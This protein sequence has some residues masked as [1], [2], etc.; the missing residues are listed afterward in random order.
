MKIVLTGGPSAGKTAL[1]TIIEKEFFG[2]VAVVPEAASI[3]FKGGFPRKPTLL[4]IKHQQR[5]IYFLQV[6]LEGL[7]E[8]ENP[9]KIIICDRGTLDGS[10]YLQGSITDFYKEVGSSLEKEIQRYDYV[11]H[12]ESPDALYYDFS[13]PLR[14][15]QPLQA[16]QLDEK[17]K[18]VWS[19]H[20]HRHITKN[21]RNF[22][23]KVADVLEKV[24]AIIKD[25]NVTR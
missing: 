22:S 17:I 5:A 7:I 19:S 2:Q 6:E 13:N 25:S 1:V 15:E 16:R 21:N 10:A 9:G 11:L 23:E 12:L 18:A 4:N 3:L 24:R 20:P 8:A 14:L